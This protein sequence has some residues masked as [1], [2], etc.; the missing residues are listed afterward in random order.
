[1]FRTSESLFSLFSELFK[2]LTVEE[3]YFCLTNGKIDERTCSLLKNEEV[4][5]LAFFIIWKDKCWDGFSISKGQQIL[6]ENFMKITLAEDKLEDHEEKANSIETVK[7][8]GFKETA[9]DVKY[10]LGGVLTVCERGPSFVEW[11]TLEFKE[12]SG[13]NLKDVSE[14]ETSFIKKF[15]QFAC[16]CLNRRCDGTIYFGIADDKRGQYEHGEVVGMQ[17]VT[18]NQ[19]N[20]FQEWLE[21]HISK[22]RGAKRFQGLKKI[23]GSGE[24]TKAFATCVGPVRA[25]EI[26]GSPFL[27]LE[28]DVEASSLV[29]NSMTFFYSN[30]ENN[31][32]I[33]MREGTETMASKDLDKWST[34][35]EK[36]S[37]LRQRMEWERS[38]TGTNTKEKLTK[39]ICR[40]GTEI[41]YETYRYHLICN[42]PANASDAEW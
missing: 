7:P 1:M 35:I 37:M 28:I 21:T 15:I 3:L 20:R 16:G 33:C 40:T 6:I 34:E 23:A 18:Q 17:M 19:V 41:D 4:N 42:K 8:R 30:L 2:S 31:L 25:I 27:V 13:D 36:Y 11:H 14:Y 9:H 10:K 39:L 22:G 5:G 32:E 29:C 24:M 38:V 12:F 26:E